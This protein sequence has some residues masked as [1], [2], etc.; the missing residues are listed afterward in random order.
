MVEKI[1]SGINRM[2]GGMREANLPDP[3]FGL[4][5]IFSS[6]FPRPVDFESW[7]KKWSGQLTTPLIKIIHG[8]YDNPSVTKEELSEIIGQGK[9]S[10]DNHINKLKKLGLIQRIGS[11]KAGRWQINKYSNK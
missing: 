6:S 2:I 8:V 11:R 10:V 7:M 5:G 9:T 3:K 4:V 1:G